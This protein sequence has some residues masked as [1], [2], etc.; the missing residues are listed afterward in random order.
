M[1][2]HLQVK[3]GVRVSLRNKAEDGRPIETPVPE[4]QASGDQEDGIDALRMQRREPQ[5]IPDLVAEGDRAAFGDDPMLTSGDIHH[6]PIW[7]GYAF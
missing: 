2:Q 6:S 7:T 5:L 4:M 1:Q 3:H